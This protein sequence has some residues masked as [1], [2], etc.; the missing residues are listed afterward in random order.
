MNDEANIQANKPDDLPVVGRRRGKPKGHPKP[1]GSGRKPGVPNRATRD[2]RAA[3]QKHSAKAI[4]ALARQLADPDPKV[5]A[6]AAREILDR[7]HGRPMTPNELTGKDGAPLNPSS[8]LMGDTELARMLTFMVAKGAKDLV[9]GQ[10]E[11]ER[12]RAVAVEAD[13]HQAA[14]EHH[15]DAIAVQAN[16][17]HP[18]AAYWATHT[19]E[20][21]GDNA[22]PPLS[23][24]T[25]LPVVRRTRE[26]G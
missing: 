5:V 17:A 19:E 14:R 16:E 26:H 25:E 1:E 8:D 21:R 12:K 10:A 24:V 23:N 6:I 15:R 20:R 9:E 3:A 11:T 4:A 13:R 22:P 2:V 7:A 18:R